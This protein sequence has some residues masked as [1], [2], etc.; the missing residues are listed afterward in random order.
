MHISK[1]KSKITLAAVWKEVE[2]AG[3]ING[4]DH[5]GSYQSAPGKT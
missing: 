1:M 2:S 3:R 4:G 5:L